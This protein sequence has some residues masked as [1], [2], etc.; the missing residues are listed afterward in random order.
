MCVAFCPQIKCSTSKIFTSI[1]TFRNSLI[2]IHEEILIINWSEKRKKKKKLKEIMKN[3]P[4][5]PGEIGPLHFHWCSNKLWST[6]GHTNCIGIRFVN[7]LLFQSCFLWSNKKE[8]LANYGFF[9]L[10]LLVFRMVTRVNVC[11]LD[12]VLL[13]WRFQRFWQLNDFVP[14]IYVHMRFVE[15]DGLPRCVCMWQLNWNLVQTLCMR[16]KFSSV[17]FFIDKNNAAQRMIF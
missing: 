9:S 1:D 4:Y 6:C 17:F 13:L 3:N 7:F 16:S 15:M 12:G 10:R 8:S 11:C 2:I 14:T 5:L